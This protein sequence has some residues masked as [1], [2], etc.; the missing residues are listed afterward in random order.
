MA[1]TYDVKIYSNQLFFFNKSL[2]K[3]SV[4]ISFTIGRQKPQLLAAFVRRLTLIKLLAPFLI[5]C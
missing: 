3:V 2:L 1:L 5:A 4:M